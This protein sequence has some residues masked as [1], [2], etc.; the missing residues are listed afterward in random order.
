MS[1]STDSFVSVVASYKIDPGDA[2]TFAKIAAESVTKTVSKPGCLYYTAS[3]DVG[4]PGL[5]HL[6]EGWQDQAALDKHAN[7]PDFR[8]TLE[9]AMKLRILS[10]LIYVAE[11]RGRKLVS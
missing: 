7:S 3:E 6:S 9:Q 5:F 2:A 8:E 1:M 4:E 11:A 10:R